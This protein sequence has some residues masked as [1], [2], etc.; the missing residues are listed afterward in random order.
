MDKLTN[1]TK[2]KELDLKIKSNAQIAQG[3]LWEMCKGLAEMRDSKLYKE[4]GYS[5]FEE[6]S[7][8]EIGIKRRQAYNY[9]SIFETFK[10]ESVQPVAQNLGMRKLL[11]LAKLDE[12]ERNKIIDT[13]AVEDITVKKLEEEI[14][15]LKEA[16]KTY[17]KRTTERFEGMKAAH[18]EEIKTLKND[19]ETY[20]RQR[21]NLTV[22]L[23]QS[24][25]ENEALCEQIQELESRPVEVAVTD[26]S[27]EI[28]N[29][30][31]AMAKQDLEF[32]K[33]NRELQEEQ[34]RT[35]REHAQAI[36]ALRKEYEAKIAEITQQS[37]KQQT[38]DD[39]DT[40][41][42]KN[43]LFLTVLTTK[44]LVDFLKSHKSEAFKEKSTTLFSGL[45]SEINKIGG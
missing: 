15:V 7:E 10:N 34:F 29:M 21:D 40:Q 19:A 4:L 33:I 18:A 1:L 3:A 42:F 36:D 9:I 30:R 28:E 26:N 43:Y 22:L 16:S 11:L 37:A 44:A 2:A 17:E 32:Q 24:K 25:A 12:Q 41:A 38:D 13:V 35:N 20:E 31:K 6:Y 8:Q 23:N 14:K 39:S 27:H 45:I 5:S